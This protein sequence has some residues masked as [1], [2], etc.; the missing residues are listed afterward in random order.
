[1]LKSGKQ[2]QDKAQVLRNSQLT[3]IGVDSL[4]GHICFHP[5][6]ADGSRT[7]TVNKVSRARTKFNQD[8]PNLLYHDY[9]KK[10]PTITDIKNQI[11]DCI[12]AD[13]DYIVTGGPKEESLPDAKTRLSLLAANKRQD[14]E[15]LFS[16]HYTSDDMIIN[17]IARNFL[18]QIDIIGLQVGAYSAGPN[19]MSKILHKVRMIKIYTNKPVYLLGVPSYVRG[20]N[21]KDFRAFPYYG[22][23]SEGCAKWWQPIPIKEDKP[24]KAIDAEDYKCKNYETFLT[25]LGSPGALMPGS[26][27]TVFEFFHKLPKKD[28]D[29]YNKSVLD[30]ETWTMREGTLDEKNRAIS[31]IHPAYYPDVN[32]AWRTMELVVEPTKEL[33]AQNPNWNQ[34]D[35]RLEMRRVFST[36]SI[37]DGQK[38]TR[39][40][41]DLLADN[42]KR[43]NMP[44]QKYIEELEN[45]L[46]KGKSDMPV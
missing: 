32:D 21:D 24:V 42:I 18:N 16:F 20:D 34:I 15:S 6:E 40:A 26:S 45:I 30:Q 31:K 36:A 44:M 13:A 4:P 23:F 37:E 43:G 14:K 10:K 19:A 7:D 5:I 1:M 41:F 33:L 12:T 9:K 3:D 29:L 8:M 39:F 27:I 38:A 2:V 22:L 11:D 28:V 17:E 35:L 46:R 25:K